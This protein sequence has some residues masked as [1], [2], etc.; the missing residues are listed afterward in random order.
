MKS[1][2][3]VLLIG[4]VCLVGCGGSGGGST[5]CGDNIEFQ[6][7]H[8]DRF[9]GNKSC[10]LHDD[11]LNTNGNYWDCSSG[12]VSVARISAQGIIRHN[13]SFNIKDPDIGLNKYELKFQS[14]DNV[15]G[16]M[17]LDVSTRECGREF[18][19]TNYRFDGCNA[20]RFVN[21][22]DG[23]GYVIDNLNGGFMN[24][25]YGFDSL[26]GYVDGVKVTMHNVVY[27][28]DCRL[29]NISS[30]SVSRVKSETVHTGG[31]DKDVYSESTGEVESI[32][33]EVINN[34]LL[35]N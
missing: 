19:E 31:E 26:S 18:G 30:N 15:S 35:K 7:T 34:V 12:R 28:H 5:A 14:D 25:I 20:V 6:T 13:I 24:V 9:T 8:V 23:S 27:N 16:T 2:F 17:S 21:P 10:V 29:R 11:F 1:L 3:I 32:L 22:D 33:S 4:I